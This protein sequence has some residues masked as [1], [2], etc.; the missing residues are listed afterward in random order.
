[1]S[2]R[3]FTR[4][5]LTAA[6]LLWSLSLSAASDFRGPSRDDNGNVTP[7]PKGEQCIRPTAEIRRTHPELLLHKRDQT[8]RQGIRTKDASLKECINCHV[9]PGENGKVAR[10]GEPGFFCSSCH[11]SVSVKLDCFEC[12]SDRPES[13]VGELSRQTSPHGKSSTL[14]DR[15]LSL[16]NNPKA[17]AQQKVR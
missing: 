17:V 6:I 12:H 10:A 7:P 4:W 5:L 13:A 15:L 14:V 3:L 1:M 16:S 2:I 11:Q 8:M 9:T